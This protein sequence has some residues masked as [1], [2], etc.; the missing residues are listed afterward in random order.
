MLATP[1]GKR[2]ATKAQRKRIIASAMRCIAMLLEQME[3]NM[4]LR[5]IQHNWPYCAR[6]ACVRARRCRGAKR[7]RALPLPSQ[8]MPAAKLWPR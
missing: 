4:L 7:C 8:V 6:S 2:D 5:Q 3:S 1:D